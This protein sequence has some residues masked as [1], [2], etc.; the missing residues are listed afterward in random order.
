MLDVLLE[1]NPPKPKA[2]VF[3]HK[4]L[5][6]KKKIVILRDL[7]HLSNSTLIE[8]NLQK[9]PLN[10]SNCRWAILEERSTLGMRKLLEG[11]KKKNIKLYRLKRKKEVICRHI[12]N[13]HCDNSMISGWKPTKSDLRLHAK[14]VPL[15]EK[16]NIICKKETVISNSLHSS[17]SQL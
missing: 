16:S 11:K 17:I 5:L 9:L 14:C 3:F 2:K 12:L 6:I 10:T 13:G 15:K 1:E 8:N 7:T 4:C